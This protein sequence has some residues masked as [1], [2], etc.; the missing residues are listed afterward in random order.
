MSLIW[1]SP[2]SKNFTSHFFPL[3]DAW[4]KPFNPFPNNKFRRFQTEKKFADGNFK[5]DVNGRKFSKRL[6]NTVGKG[7][8]LVTTT[9]R[10][11]PDQ[12]HSQARNLLWNFSFIG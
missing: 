9:S 12:D 8:L 1:M 5:F 3:S 4:T 7:E 11:S 6:E 10:K 2:L